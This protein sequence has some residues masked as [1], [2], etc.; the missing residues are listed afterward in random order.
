MWD[1]EL[2]EEIR[3]LMERRRLAGKDVIPIFS[4]IALHQ[5]GAITASTI[6]AFKIPESAQQICE[7]ELIKTFKRRYKPF[8]TK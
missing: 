8:Y 4:F 7:E 6:Q 1:E 5:S 2:A 3:Q